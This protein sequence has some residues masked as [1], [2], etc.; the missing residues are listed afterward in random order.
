LIGPRPTST[1]AAITPPHI[2]P[3]STGG[4]GG[5]GGDLSSSPSPST[6]PRAAKLGSYLPWKGA[7]RPCARCKEQRCVS[8][9]RHFVVFIL[10]EACKNVS[11][12]N[13][14]FLWL[15]TQYYHHVSLIKAYW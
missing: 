4:A 10:H 15:I 9:S 11:Y 14:H 2:S 3:A 12:Q 6:L 8:F 7:R 5:E 1:A 13:P